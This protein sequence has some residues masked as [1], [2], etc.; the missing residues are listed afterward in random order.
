MQKCT[1]TL[2]HRKSQLWRN[3][4]VIPVTWEKEDGILWSETGEKL[5]PV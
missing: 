3:M 5:D 1:K 2:S 4:P